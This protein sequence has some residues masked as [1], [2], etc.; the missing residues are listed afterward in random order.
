MK[1][2]GKTI[3]LGLGVSLFVLSAQADDQ[4]G[5]NYISLM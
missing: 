4:P 5:D 2:I 3:L 1:S